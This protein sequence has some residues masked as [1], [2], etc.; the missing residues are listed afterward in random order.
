M[1]RNSVVFPWHAYWQMGWIMDYMMSEAHLRSNGQV[2]FPYGYMTPKVGPHVT[3]GFAPG[4]IYGH[5]ADLVLRPDMIVSDNADV[6]YI[7]ARSTDGK[8]L[9]LVVLSQSPRAQSCTLTMDLSKLTG[10]TGGFKKVV[11]I[12]GKT[13]KVDARESRISFD[14]APGP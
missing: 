6:E 11:S 12:Q 14:F 3:Y 7:T 2:K 13:K 9:Y 5:K 10:K 1:K 8:K 4:D